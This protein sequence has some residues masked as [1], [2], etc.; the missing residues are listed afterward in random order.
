MKKISSRWFVWL[1]ALMLFTGGLAAQDLGAVR[2]SMAKRLPQID[3]LKAEGAIGENNAGFVE[4]R[5]GGAPVAA[6]ADA[7]NGDRRV[8]YAAIAQKTGA[9]VDEVGR[10]RARQIAAGSAP[11]VWLQDASGK[12]YQK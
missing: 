4:S 2:D 9:S 5:S 3:K 8:V 11:G 1:A 6:V 10:A 7:E 12:W